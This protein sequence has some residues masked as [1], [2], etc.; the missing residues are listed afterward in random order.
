MHLDSLPTQ[1]TLSSV[2]WAL[3]APANDKRNNDRRY[4]TIVQAPKTQDRNADWT[5]SWRVCEFV[6]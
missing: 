4:V 3:P 5:G 6:T 1:A 2:H